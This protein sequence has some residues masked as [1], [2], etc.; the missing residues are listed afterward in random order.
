MKSQLPKFP[1]KIL[2]DLCD[3]RY[4]EEIDGDLE[5]IYESNLAQFGRRAANRIYW[6]DVLKHIRPYFIRKKSINYI[7]QNQTAMWSIYL[8]IALRNFWKSK[9]ISGINT[10]G[11][12]LG[13]AC[14][15]I[16]FFHVKDE[17]SYD[18]FIENGDNIYRVLNIRPESEH[19]ASAGGP[20]PLGPALLDEF[21]GIEDAVRLWRDYQ[22]T[23][24]L[25]ER[26]FVEDEFI[27]TDPSFF[28]MFSFSLKK[29]DPKTAL[30][31]PNTVILT[32][33]MVRK[34]FG[35]G[36][37]MGKII[38]YKG[39]RG[40]KQLLVTGVMDDLPHNTHMTFDF[41]ASFVNVSSQDNWGSFKP[42]WTYITLR[43]G[44]SPKDIIAGFPDF[45]KKHV[46]YRVKEYP[47]FRF[48]LE[49]MSGIYMQSEAR[50][51]MKP[52]GDLQ[53]IYILSIVGISILLIA[54]INFINLTLANSLV[55][56]KEVGIRKI[57]GAGK[58]QLVRQ[59]LTES[60]VTILLAFTASVFLTIIFLPLY[61]EFSDKQINFMHLLD[62]E[63]VGYVLLGLL[64]A[65]FLAGLYPARFIS[66]FGNHL[67]LGRTSDKIGTNSGARRGFVVFQFLVSAILI[68]SILIIK[69]QQT[70]IFTKQLG[71]DKDHVMVV[72]VSKNEDAFLQ[73]LNA[74]P[75]VSSFGISQRLPVNVLNYDG[76]SFEVE[77][78][79]R[80][81]SAQSC[82]IDFDFI[83]TYGIELIAGRNHYKELSSQWEFLINESAVVE[84]EWGTPENALGKKIFLS[85][86]H[87]MVGNVIGVFKDYHLESL[88]EKIPPMIM[89]K[90]INEEWA[91]W[92]REFVS[93]K[94]NTDNLVAF[95]SEI[96]DLWKS[97][98]E[99]SA[100]FSFFI[101]DSYNSLHEADHKFAT[102]FNYVTF[103]AMLIACMGLL[104]LSML[105]VNQK[106]KEIGIR[107]VL[108]ASVFSVTMLFSSRFIGL[109]LV[110]LV[111]ACPFAYYL[112]DQWLEG[113]SY[114]IIIGPQP[115]VIA[116]GIVSILAIFTIVIHTT[117][118]A[119]TNPA[120]SL[121]DE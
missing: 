66:K 105:I 43:D 3:K 115:F 7:T 62:V 78:L 108:G 96:E 89:F 95:T 36:D 9:I 71:I 6:L 103:I 15:I 118:A 83:E 23:L 90:N 49:Q 52:L 33:S 64:G 47:G 56:F 85:P 63:F 13:L 106:V 58:S 37:P 119:L 29:G 1:R 73:D 26:V 32:Q 45:A 14:C 40:N 75:Q 5:E 80:A 17:L 76:R 30:A 104:G 102:L 21:A 117:R 79:N 12:S 67:V 86:N 87:G 46:P 24:S 57:M 109:V 69:Q 54:C 120:E 68:I 4:L 101:D 81:V 18:E 94:Y 77:G 65:M 44:V 55:R 50:R 112:M 121:K 82:V 111:L 8:K 74:M 42:I 91:G 34:Y 28:Q 107:K 19:P 20:V 61:N 2:H 51:N 100:Y 59:F 93:I 116:F 88:H 41:L 72:P 97:Y 35:D 114:R 110:G 53:S 38:N 10:L 25:G 84:F 11:L 39:G 27:F 113:F 31:Q 60:A 70:Y 98:N 48:D 16:V 92:H 22:P 99:G